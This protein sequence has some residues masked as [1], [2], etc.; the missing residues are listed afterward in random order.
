MASGRKG[1]MIKIV[2]T[3]VVVLAISLFRQLKILV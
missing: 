1:L 3:N 2:D